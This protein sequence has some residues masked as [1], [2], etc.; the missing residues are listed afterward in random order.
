MKKKIIIATLGTLFALMLVGCQQN[1]KGNGNKTTINRDLSTFQN[2]RLNGNYQVN[3]N[4][5][6]AQQVSITTDAN[7]VPY[8]Q[9]RVSGN[10][11]TIEN[12]RRTYIE[13]T[14]TPQL[15]IS[16]NNLNQINIVGNGTVNVNGI[17]TNQFRI[18]IVGSGEATV[19]G[20]ADRVDIKIDGSGQIA[21]N[22]LVAQEATVNL[23]GSGLISLLASQRLNINLNGAGKVQYYGE[24]REV[25]QRIN[26]SGQVIGIPRNAQKNQS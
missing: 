13:P 21:A 1:I 2:I 19:S 15:N 26:G 10:T 3:V 7:L 24:P 9:T 12:Q 17:R 6:K 23:S 20:N 4:V 8:I 5:G 16:V 18:N 25:T 14:E 11:L 22:N